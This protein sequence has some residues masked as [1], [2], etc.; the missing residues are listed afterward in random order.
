MKTIT[1]KLSTTPL[2]IMLFILITSCNY[3]EKKQINQEE[4]TASSLPYI[5]KTNGV[6]QLIV[7]DVPFVILGG[8]LL[9]SSASSIEYMEPI[10]PRMKSFNVNTILLPI[11]WQQFEPVEGEFDYSLVDNHIK[12]AHENG[13]RIVILWFGSW[14]NGRSHYTPDWV[15]TDLNRFPRMQYKN[16]EPTYTISN[17]NDE[18]LKADKNA[19]I[20]LMEHIAQVDQHNTV[21]MMQIE[22]EVGL[23]GGSRDFSPTAT[24]LFEQQV[25]MKLIDHINQHINNIKPA[26]LEAYQNNGS[27]TQGSWADIFGKSLLTDE[28]FMA[29]NYAIY[30]NQIS[31]AGK[32]VHNIPTLVNTWASNKNK[33]PGD[34]PSGGPNYR[35]L[36]VWQAG[37]PDIDILAIDNYGKYFDAK[38]KEFIHQGNPLFIP[39]ASAI[40][41]NDTISAPEKAFYTIGHYN[42]I[43]FSPFGIDHDNYHNNHPIKNAYKV[44]N[45][46]MPLITK[47]QLENK[48]NAFME[49]DAT[50]PSTF[51][52]G[53]YKFTP[54]YD[55]KKAPHIKGFGMVIQTGKDDFIVAGN[56]FRLSYGSADKDKPTAQL[57][58]VEEGTFVDGEWQKGRV[59]NGDEFNIKFPPTAY[60]RSENVVLGDVAISKFKMFKY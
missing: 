5:K 12:R 44:L 13:L 34:W 30:I 22:N 49:D 11:N 43:C 6:K 17:F 10:W 59:L 40:F 3:S 53:D 42:A 37:A 4:Q 52:L 23:L 18:C 25:P 35:M 28:I 47:A 7:D 14:K 1:S 54:I 51:V 32:A 27:K 46:L 20:K 2:I 48:I 60:N 55:R 19:Y 36:D 57:L 50:S 24:E 45:D 33:N 15:K 9:N 41:Y 8:E 21:L 31:I 16:Q 56:A 29:W 39:E 58:S 38:C 26:I